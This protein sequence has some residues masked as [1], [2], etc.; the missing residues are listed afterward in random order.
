MRKISYEEKIQKNELLDIISP[1]KNVSLGIIK[2][3]DDISRKIYDILNTKDFTHEMFL[4]ILNKL[5]IWDKISVNWIKWSVIG[6]KTKWN[7]KVGLIIWTGDS[8]K[9]IIN[10]A[11]SAITNKIN[12]LRKPLGKKEKNER[13][14]KKLEEINTKGKIWEIKDM[15]SDDKF[16]KEI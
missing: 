16:T 8:D 11:G 4:E 2:I 1:I 12:I 9:V 3:R 15:K 13:T 6:F 5:N 14:W 10:S 7:Q